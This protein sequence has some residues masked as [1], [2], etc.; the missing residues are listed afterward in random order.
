MK[1]DNDILKSPRR[2]P[3]KLHHA[4]ADDKSDLELSLE[5]GKVPKYGRDSLEQGEPERWRPKS[6]DFITASGVED[7]EEEL[8][9][10]IKPAKENEDPEG[11]S[12]GQGSSQDAYEPPRRTHW[13]MTSFLMMVYLIG[14]GVLSLPSAFVSM[15]WIAGSLILF[16]IVFITTITGYYMWFLHMKYP[17]IR[18][19]AAMFYK[20]FG[21]TGQ[22]IGGGLTYT[23]FFGILT[24]DLLTMSLSWDSL[25]AGHHVCVEVWFVISFIVFFILG[26]VRS[27]H[28]VSWIAVISMICIFLPVILTLSQVPKL[29]V[30][31]HAYTTIGGTGFVAGTVGMTD[32]VFAFAGHLIFYEIMAEM[33]D[34]RDFPKALLTSQIV[35]YVLCMFTAS[36]VYAY[37]GNTSVLQSPVTL[38]LN[39]S[40]I[41]DASNVMLIIHVISPGLMGGTV[42]SRAFQRW[43]Q[44]WSRRTFDDHSWT[45]RLS[46]LIW[47]ATV[48]GLAF[49]V[50]SL[51]PF[52]NELIGLIAALVSSSTTFG[53]PAI[54]YLI[55]FR[56]QTPWWNWILALSCIAIGYSLLG[57][58]SYAGI[59]SIIQAVPNHGLPFSCSR[60]I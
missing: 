17:H 2:S 3:M 20:F 45:Q 44:C 39:H 9:K 52:F 27:L 5:E 49:I 47:S 15:G 7:T 19:Y 25:F 12:V 42:L 48:Y 46:Y 6:F 28:D 33:K 36:F 26:Q 57:L 29:A 1:K 38:S 43:L 56:K 40:A 21:K 10:A 32:I 24:A 11:G 53:M 54:M 35:G 50:A 55:E 14:V 30:G 23:Y 51:I 58:G 22:Y 37:I 4:S 60:K 41:R 13:F 8:E 18:S 16:L 59:Y 31:T 34:V